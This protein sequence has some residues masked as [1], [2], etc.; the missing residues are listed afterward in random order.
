M[1]RYLIAVFCVLTITIGIYYLGYIKG[2]HNA[3]NTY[4]NL[5]LDQLKTII[6]QSTTLTRQAQQ[7]SAQ[8]E[9]VTASLTEAN[10]QSTRDIKNA[11]KQSAHSRTSCVFNA[12]I[13]R[14]LESARHRAAVATNASHIDDLLPA[15]ASNDR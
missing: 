1:S 11:L 14:E 8:L 2:Q 5:Q 7:A 4:N 15:A 3:E 13:M 6:S 9:K 10:I 12:D